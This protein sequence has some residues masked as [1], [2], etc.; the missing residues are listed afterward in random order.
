[1]SGWD[2]QRRPAQAEPPRMEALARLPVFLALEG[3]RAVVAGDG[4]AAAWKA[5]LLSAAGAQVEVFAESPCDE[6]R[7][8]SAKPP[9]GAVTLHRRAWR[10]ADFVGAAI[11]VGGFDDDDEARTLCRAPHAQPACRSM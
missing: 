11:A 2:T 9:R 7:T 8:L 6:L 5:E 10:P 4:P 1:M 3:K